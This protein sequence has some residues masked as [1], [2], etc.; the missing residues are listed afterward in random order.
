MGGGTIRGRP[1]W[2]ESYGNRRPVT[3]YEHCPN[4]PNRQNG[5]GTTRTRLRL[6]RERPMSLQLTIRARW[7]MSHKGITHAIWDGLRGVYW[8]F[9]NKVATIEE[10]DGPVIIVSEPIET[11]EA[12]LGRE[13]FAPNWEFSYYERGED[14]NVARIIHEG[15]TVD[16]H[17]Y[18]W[19][20]THVRGW[21][22]ADGSVRLRAH[23]ELEP[24]ENDQDHIDGVGFDEARGL[25]ETA[26][27]LD[28]QELS[29][30]RLDFLPGGGD[31]GT[32][33]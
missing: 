28:S 25:E 15:R 2:D 13:Y 26:A 8:A 32:S 24:T 23:F 1:K 16:G 9:R 3:T 20:Q 12:A 31:S 5:T 17:A 6:S 18:D 14:V 21:R 7:E 4:R 29:Y 33:G 22:Q 30:E 10:P 11:V 27:A 19:W